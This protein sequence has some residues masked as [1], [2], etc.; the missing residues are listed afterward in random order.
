[1]DSAASLVSIPIITLLIIG[2]ATQMVGIAD[3]VTDKTVLYAEEMNKAVDCAFYGVPLDQCSKM[4]STTDFRSD[5]SSFEAEI[6]DLQ[7]NIENQK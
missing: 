1:M 7:N 6:Q 2:I 4:L 5:L 3:D